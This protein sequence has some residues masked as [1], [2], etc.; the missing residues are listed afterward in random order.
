METIIGENVPEWRDFQG[1]KQLVDVISKKT[2]PI[3]SYKF[4]CPYF[5][6]NG[7]YRVN[8]NVPNEYDWFCDPEFVPYKAKGKFSSKSK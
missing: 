5:F 1:S 2:I 3:C 4:N 8:P 6:D 7:Y